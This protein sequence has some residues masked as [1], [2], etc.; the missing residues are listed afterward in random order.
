MGWVEF[1]VRF[2]V[3][4]GLKDR[5]IIL[6]GFVYGVFVVCFEFRFFRECFS[7]FLYFL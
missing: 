2:L 3:K 6:I 1:T 7:L 4:L 5:I